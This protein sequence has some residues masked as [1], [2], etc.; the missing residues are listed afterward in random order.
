MA[1]PKASMDQLMGIDGF[2]ACSLVDSNSGMVLAQAG[3]G[4]MF[5]LK[6]AAAG[7]TEVVRAKRKS[8]KA[9]DLKDAIESLLG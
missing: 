8:I 5:N 3:G 4:P 7:N 6:V 1:N 2:I 9:L